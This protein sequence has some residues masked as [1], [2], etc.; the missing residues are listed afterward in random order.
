MQLQVS[1]IIKGR[2]DRKKGG[3]GGGGAMGGGD[4]REGQRGWRDRGWGN[5]EG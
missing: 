1:V 5:E 3:G 4:G 2:V